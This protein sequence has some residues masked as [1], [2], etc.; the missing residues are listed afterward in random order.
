MDESQKY[1]D[2]VEVAK[3]RQDPKFWKE[4][5]VYFQSLSHETQR[6]IIKKQFANIGV[7]I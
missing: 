4:I 2:M 6:E 3:K 7:P 1:L 5:E